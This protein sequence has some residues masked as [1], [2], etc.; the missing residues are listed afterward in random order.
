MDAFNAI[1]DPDAALDFRMN[2]AEWLAS[3]TILTSTWIADPGVTVTAHSKTDTVATA[4][5]SGGQHGRR[6]HI[7]NRITTAAGRTDDR[8]IVLSVENR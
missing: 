8:T 2:W 4:W 3:D 5:L 1:K 7:T 6:Y